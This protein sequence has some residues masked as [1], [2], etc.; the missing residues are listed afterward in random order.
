MCEEMQ[1]SC[2][3]R[4]SHS[5]IFAFGLSPLDSW[6]KIHLIQAT[7]IHCLFFFFVGAM[8]EGKTGRQL[9]EELAIVP[10]PALTLHEIKCRLKTEFPFLRNRQGLFVH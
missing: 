1:T 2:V 10:S 5:E 9:L 7:Q 8:A 4:Q 3:L 6:L